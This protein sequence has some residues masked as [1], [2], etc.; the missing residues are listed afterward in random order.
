MLEISS[1]SA[2]IYVKSAVRLRQSGAAV[3]PTGY[4]VQAAFLDDPDAAPVSGDWKT[5]SWETDS[6]TSPATYYARCLVGA[7]GAV[8]LVAGV[9]TM[10]VKV[11]G[12]PEMPVLKCGLVKVI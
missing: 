12:S 4:T 3:D 5:A 8:T 11:T 1:A 7:S 6:T 2:P 9:Y 10:H